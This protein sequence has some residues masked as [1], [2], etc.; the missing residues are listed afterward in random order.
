MLA[1]K[2][3]RERRYAGVL[4]L[5][6]LGM[7]L[8]GGALAHQYLMGHGGTDRQ[9]QQLVHPLYTTLPQITA[10]TVDQRLDRDLS[11]PYVHGV[12]R[13]VT[14]SPTV[15]T[16]ARPNERFGE[17]VTDFPFAASAAYSHGTSPYPTATTITLRVPGG[18]TA[19]IVTRVEG[20][21]T[22]AANE[23]LFV[24]VRDQGAVAGGNTKTVLVVS[25]E[26]DVFQVR[27][28]I[29]HGQGALSAFSEPLAVFQQHF[30][31]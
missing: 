25:S 28:G 26:G 18:S 8:C 5:V 11:W 20:A 24:F 4:L 6:L 15:R 27:G 21:P 2:I 16:L 30:A 22:V 3:A 14:G 13:G 10:L 19:S 23:E 7:V 12:L 31:H 29:V 1:G 9:V 17:V